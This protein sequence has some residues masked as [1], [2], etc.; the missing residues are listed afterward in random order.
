MNEKIEIIKKWIEK[1]DHDLKTAMISQ[2]I[3][4]S[5]LHRVIK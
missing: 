4:F 1:G 5:C 3:I 2:I